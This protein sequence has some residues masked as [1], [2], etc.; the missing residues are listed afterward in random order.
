MDRRYCIGAERK[1]MG[2]WRCGFCVMSTTLAGR[3]WPPDMGGGTPGN[4]GRR[5]RVLGFKAP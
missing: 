2:V 3:P 5:I 4:P 1:L